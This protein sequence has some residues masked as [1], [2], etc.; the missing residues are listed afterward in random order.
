MRTKNVLDMLLAQAKQKL[1]EI[2]QLQFFGGD[3]LNLKRYVVDIVIPPDI[4]THCW[5]IVMMPEN[6]D[7]TMPIGVIVKPGKPIQSRIYIDIERVRRDDGNFEY[8][9]ISDKNYDTDAAIYT[10]AITYSGKADFA[11]TQL[12]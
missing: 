7:T 1:E 2:K 4:R 3:A 9:F 12:A 8:L 5:R 6:K 10:I 11:I